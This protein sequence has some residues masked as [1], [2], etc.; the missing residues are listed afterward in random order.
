[1]DNLDFDPKHIK[2]LVNLLCC[3][4]LE[5]SLLSLALDPGFGSQEGPRTGPYG[6]I[7]ACMGPYGRR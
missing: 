2:D 6:P 1:M 7:S 4:V 5:A 3:I